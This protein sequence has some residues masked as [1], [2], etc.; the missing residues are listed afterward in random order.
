MDVSMFTSKKRNLA[1]NLITISV[2]KHHEKGTDLVS[3]QIKSTPAHRK[4]L[5]YFFSKPQ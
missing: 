2:L 1:M 3:V 4:E 5:H